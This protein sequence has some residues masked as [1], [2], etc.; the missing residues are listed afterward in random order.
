MIDGEFLFLMLV[1]LADMDVKHLSQESL[2]RKGIAHKIEPDA[3]AERAPSTQEVMFW[4]G[5]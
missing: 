3:G 5:F 4:F 1:N 2:F